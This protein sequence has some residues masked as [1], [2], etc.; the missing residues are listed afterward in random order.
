MGLIITLILLGIL[1]IIAE[2]V[3]IPGIFLTGL[4]GLASLV[5]SCYIGWTQYG[6]TGG[7]ITIAVNIILLSL[8]IIL[9]LRSK[10]WNKL[11]LK[12]EIDSKSDKTPQEKG[13]HTGMEGLTL[14]RLAPMGKVLL[15]TE[16]VE[17]T[18]AEGIIDPQSPVEITLIEEN[19]IYVKA[20]K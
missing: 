13:I 1:L 18:S 3:L 9:A 17:A 7:I 10:T 6:Q 2:I 12:T 20:R 11:S 5:G 8:F 15:G 16:A 4:L 19:K 14:T